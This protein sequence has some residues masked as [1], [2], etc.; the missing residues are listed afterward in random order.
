MSTS[1]YFT[2]DVPMTDIDQPGSIL[3]SMN[4]GQALAKFYSADV[5]DDAA[6]A[7]RG[8]YVGRKIDMVRVIIPGDKHNIVERRVREPDKARWPKAWEAYRKMEDFVPDGTLIDTWPML[9]RAQVEDMK[10]NNIYTVEQLAE[11]PDSNLSALGLGARMMRKHAQA[12]I[13]AS[14]NGAVPAQLVSE[15]EHLRQHVSLLMNQ[16]AELTKKVEVFAAKAGEK[17]EDIA[18]P[19]A[20]AKLAIN[21]A[22]GSEQFVVIPD[23]YK[24]MGL[25]ALKALCTKFSG[26]KVLDKE[27]AFELIAEYQASRKVR[28]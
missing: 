20:Q 16:L 5:R 24:A 4:N 14:K 19:V 8:R 26:A 23:N 2:R 18:D 21:E 9:S 1:H 3:P 17:I 11:L 7:A 28:V 27:G 13:E 10:Y 12:F 25:P 6:S 15:N 22:A